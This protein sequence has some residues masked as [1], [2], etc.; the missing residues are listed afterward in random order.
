MSYVQLSEGGFQVVYP[1]G[2]WSWLSGVVEVLFCA[3]PP[4]CTRAL[5]SMPAWVWRDVRYIYIFFSCMDM[6][7]KLFTFTF[8]FT[9]LVVPACRPGSPVLSKQP[10]KSE[11]EKPPCGETTQHAPTQTP[12]NQ[13]ATAIVTHVRSCQSPI[14][15]WLVNYVHYLHYLHYLHC[16]KPCMA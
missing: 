10:Q 8:T 13:P 1:L 3:C 4:L 7:G 11:R 15:I 6:A 5:W 16:L 12:C 9:L 2:L 14:R